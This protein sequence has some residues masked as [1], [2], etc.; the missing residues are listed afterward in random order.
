MALG[1]V[2]SHLAAELSK[3]SYVDIVDNNVVGTARSKPCLAKNVFSIDAKDIFKL[4]P[5][6]DAIFHLGEYSR[7]EVSVHG[8]SLV[9]K[10]WR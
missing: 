10:N 3:N 6:Y 4:D 7:V 9:F 8:A 2:G 5:I 1:H